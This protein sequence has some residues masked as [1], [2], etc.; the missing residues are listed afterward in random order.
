MI[1]RLEHD[2]M[3]EFSGGFSRT[4]PKGRPLDAVSR[5]SRKD[6]SRQEGYMEGNPAGGVF[7]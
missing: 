3:G 4:S 5:R 7:T 6:Y 2:F 1:K